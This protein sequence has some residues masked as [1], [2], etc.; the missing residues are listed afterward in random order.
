MCLF[1]II[2]SEKVKVKVERKSKS[3]LDRGECDQ[4]QNVPTQLEIIR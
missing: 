1:D 2:C 3:V 4:F